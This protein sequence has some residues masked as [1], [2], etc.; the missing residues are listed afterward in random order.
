M[1]GIARRGRIVATTALAVA[2]A[3][4]ALG[5]APAHAVKALDIECVPQPGGARFCEGT[6]AT[7]AP[8]WDGKVLLDVNVAL[9]ANAERNLP[10]I[11]QMHGWGGQKSGFADMKQW[12]ERG[13]AVLNFTSRGFNGSCGRLD[14]RLDCPEGWI[15]LMDTRYEVRD[16]QHLA[17]RLADEGL[18]DPQRIGAIGGSYGGGFSMALAA[19]RDR[20]M[21]P[22]GKYAP[23]TSPNGQ[24][25][26]I[27]AAAPLI[28]WTDLV[29]SLVPNGRTLDY[30]ITDRDDDRSPV[31]VMKQSFVAGLFATGQA[32]GYYSPPGVDAGADLNQW[33]ALTNAGEPYDANPQ[34]RSVVDEIAEHHSSYYIADDRAPAPLF[35]SNGW[36]D[37]L[38][39]VDEALR[40]YNRTR[41]RHPEA[42]IKLMFFDWGHMRG[43]GKQTD[44]ARMNQAIVAWFGHWLKG[45]GPRPA[46]DVTALTQTCPKE[47][48]SGGPFT[49]A[50][51]PDMHPGEVRQAFAGTQTIAS[52]GGDPSVNRAV[53]PVAGGGAC[54]TTPAGDLGGTATYRFARVTDGYTLLG[55]PTVIGKFAVQG[56]N[57]QIAARLWD[58]APNGAQTMVARG[59]YRPKGDASTEVFQLHPNGWRFDP[60]HVAKVE[61]LGNDA[62]YARASNGAFQVTA[63]NVELRLPVRDRPGGQV[64]DPAHPVVPAG[65]RLAPGVVRLSV[66]LR[67]RRP[68]ARSARRTRRCWSSVG[69]RVGGIGLR[70]VRRVELLVGR[71]RAGTD[72]RRPF[73]RSIRRATMRRARS[74]TLRVRALLRSGR[75]VTVTRRLRAC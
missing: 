59:V 39:P 28:P 53:D 71:R 72:G 3:G 52:A 40:F 7:R 4:A 42:A 55:A 5:A 15:K 22:D 13:Y 24:P 32:S 20:V 73:Y 21:T 31:G 17:G 27:A 30:T 43:Q 2:C 6:Q 46:S 69:V 49:A 67:Y 9:P 12:A 75:R 47:A 64:S 26:R 11:I 35:I 63:S 50:N 58:V 57:A 38:F 34:T 33:Y 62:P 45:E 16:G 61:L 37:D 60:G 68:R 36:T 10:L 23:W 25:M 65:A 56:A 41:D 74:R 66:R 70:N 1:G 8:G 51:W 44:T 18:V 19:L 14:T 48:P 29:Y 54:A